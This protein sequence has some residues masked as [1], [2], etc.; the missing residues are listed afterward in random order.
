M[1]FNFFNKKETTTTVA[2]PKKK[3]G[4]FREW[5]DAILFAVVVATLVHFLV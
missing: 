1:A 4:F 5:F 2:Q 3:K